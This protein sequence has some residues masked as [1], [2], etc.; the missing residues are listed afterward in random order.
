MIM[1]AEYQEQ[2]K[3][4]VGWVKEQLTGFKLPEDTLVGVTPLGR[5]FSAI[6]FPLQPGE[7]ELSDDVVEEQDSQEAQPA[8]QSIS[9]KPPSSAGFSFFVTGEQVE[10]RV[11]CQAVYYKEK[12][13]KRDELGR[14]TRNEW[15][16]IQLAPDD[17]EEKVFIPTGDSEYILFNDKARLSVVWR[18]HE[19]GCIVTVSISNRQE[20]A[21]RTNNK[22]KELNEKSLFEVTLTCFVESGKVANYPGVDR[23]LLSDEEKE[24]ELRYKDIVTLAVGHGT[25]VDW[26]VDKNGTTV[27]RAEF[28]P[29]VEIPQVTANTGGADSEV[30][31]FDLL[32]SCVDNHEVF[33]KLTS[34]VEGYEDWITQQQ[35]KALDEPE[36]DQKTAINLIKKLDIAKKRMVRGINLLKDSEGARFAFALANKAMLNQMIA[37]DKAKKGKAKESGD[38]KWRPFQLAFIL[39]TLA[40]T[41]DGDD[42][43]R[44]TLDLIWFPTGGGKTEAYLGLLAFLMIYRRLHYPSS[45]G[46]TV[47]IMRYTLRLLTAQQFTRAA[48]V[49]CALELIRQTDSDRLGKER[50]SIGLWVGE[51][52]SP[53]TCSQAFE[54]FNK[55]KYSKFIITNCP[56]CGAQFSEKNYLTDKDSFNYH[57]T[58]LNC[59][60][61]RNTDNILPCNT[62][63]QML[64]NEPPSLLIATV[65]KFA[66]LAW[67]ERPGIFFGIKGNRPPELIIQDELHLIASELGS[68][69]GLYELGIDTLLEKKGV[70]PKYIAST[71]TVKNAA[72]QVQALYARRMQVFPPSGLRYDDSYFAKTVPLSEKSGRMYVGF[73]A[74]FPAKTRCLSPLTATLLAAPVHLFNN[75]EEFMDS[76]W[77]QVIYH[78]SLKGVGNSRTLY[79]NDVLQYLNRLILE[80]MK[81]AIEEVQPG[82]LNDKRFESIEDYE[83]ISD[84]EIRQ[85]VSHYLPVRNL[86]IKTLTS[87]QTAEENNQVFDELTREY[88]QRDAIDVL[89]ATNMISVGLDVARL[90]LMIINGQPLTTAEYIQASSRV[91]RSMVP[92][93]VFVNY[94]KTQARS[95][96]H[97][98]NFRSYHDSFYRFVEPSSLT[99]FTYQARVRA[100]HAALVIAVRHGIKFLSSNEGAEKFK[101][102][103]EEVK[104]LISLLRRRIEDAILPF[105]Q[106]SDEEITFPEYEESLQ[107]TLQHLD[108]RINE[109]EEAVT[110]AHQTRQN[111]YYKAIDKSGESLLTDFHAE[112]HSKCNWQTLRSMRNVENNALLKLF[113]GVKLP[114]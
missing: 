112:N 57:C 42:E 19:Q 108:N 37:A 90:S 110:A 53:N 58:N 73:L 78:G 36:E 40:S 47:A 75:H 83:K 7:P 23:T 56:W 69:T 11:N 66:A 97:Y 99:P 16:R 51:A 80:N 12:D 13:Q 61:G 71:A 89:L 43:Y 79:Q 77:S 96:S 22:Y 84:P 35:E 103:D 85:I 107:Q 76:W 27:I 62:I 100:L 34:F 3:K 93:L 109:W 102:D 5:F 21:E 91:G 49:I 114:S 1:E 87:R 18:P 92:G 95:L 8:R 24:I 68:V 106:E 31:R 98:E 81:G 82:Y 30:L 50:F 41:A 111:L 17:G 9:Y 15:E 29:T 39:M 4:L 6:L 25:G 105:D 55:G 67:D 52:S 48:K 86:V 64:Y 70:R 10:L 28:M 65:D 26:L 104:E 32:L 63:D 59:D 54:Q 60:F 88:N 94:Y 101:K 38:Y 44:D 2:R 14:Y 46:G 74:Y 72:S 45:Y 33:E 20:T 113:G